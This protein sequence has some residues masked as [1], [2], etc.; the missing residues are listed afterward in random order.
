MDQI[1]EVAVAS[2]DRASRE[3]V[4]L[5]CGLKLYPIPVGQKGDWPYLATRS[6][7]RGRLCN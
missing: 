6:V 1:I 3:G 2:L 5:R 4:L 7:V